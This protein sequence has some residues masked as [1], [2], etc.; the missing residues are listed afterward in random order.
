MK[1]CIIPRYVTNGLP[2]Y[3]TVNLK[4]DGTR[5]THGRGSEGGNWRKEWVASTLHTNSECGLSI[6]TTADAHTS[7]ASSRPTPPPIK[8]E[9]SVSPKDEIWFLRVCHHISN[10]VY[11]LCANLHF[12]CMISCFLRDVDDICS[13]LG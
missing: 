12:N 10:A 1:R 11:K 7:A 13:L 5:V 8:M 4:C 2:D 9:S 3:C 6:I